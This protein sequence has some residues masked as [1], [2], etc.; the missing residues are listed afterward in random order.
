VTDRA[1][2]GRSLVVWLLAGAGLLCVAAGLFLV[3][4]FW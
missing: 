4:A 2:A 3:L 1:A